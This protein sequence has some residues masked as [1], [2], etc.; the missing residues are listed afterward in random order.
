MIQEKKIKEYWNKKPCNIGF[1]KSKMF[2]K[3]YFNEVTK[4]KI[5]CRRTYKKIYNF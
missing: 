2:S 3:K 1:S 4:K 5:F